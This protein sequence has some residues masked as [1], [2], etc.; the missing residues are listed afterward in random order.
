MCD[1]INAALLMDTAEVIGN[2]EEL[3]GG[4]EELEEVGGGIG[5]GDSC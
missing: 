1:H 4:I 2:I 3:G 5:E